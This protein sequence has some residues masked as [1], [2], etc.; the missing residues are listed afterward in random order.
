MTSTGGNETVST[1]K[2]PAGNAP[3]GAPAGSAPAAETPAE[4]TRAAAR[5]A[6][7]GEPLLEVENLGK[8][9]PVTAGLLRRQVAAGTAVDGGSFSVRNSAT[10]GLVGASCCGKSHCSPGSRIE[11][12]HRGTRVSIGTSLASPPISSGK[13]VST[14]FV[15]STRGTS[16]RVQISPSQM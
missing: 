3:D 15:V 9:F 12:P 8:H 1:E 5:P 11:S 7:D 10:L 6:P 4:E 13:G 14:S 16:G 2:T